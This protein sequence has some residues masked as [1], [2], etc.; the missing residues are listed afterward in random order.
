MNRIVQRQGAA[1]PWVEIQGG[2][3]VSSVSVNR[4]MAS[5]EA[6]HMLHCSTVSTVF[7]L[8]YRAVA[9]Y[10][11]LP[12]RPLCRRMKSDAVVVFKWRSCIANPTQAIS[13]Q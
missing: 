8:L 4:T 10:L 5:M 12:L 11:D 9:L 6:L 2:T 3:S 13:L 1:P 7:A